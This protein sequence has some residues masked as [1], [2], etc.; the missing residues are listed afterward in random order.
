MRGTHRL[1]ATLARRD[2]LG[3]VWC[4]WAAV[5]CLLAGLSLS[6][7][8]KAAPAPS[9]AATLEYEVK[10]TYLYKLA[11]FVNW[12]PD[13]FEA[14]GAPLRICVAGDDPFGD[15]L[16]HA[17]AGQHFG[18]HPFQVQRLQ[19]LPAATPC[20]IVF[21]SH[22]PTQDLDQALGTLE[23]KPVLTVLDSTLPGHGGVVQFVMDH[24]HVKFAIDVAAAARNHLTIN[25]KLLNLALKVR[26]TS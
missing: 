21:V 10:A 8:C 26:G 14:A 22:L 9:P 4:H 6:T 17:V 1:M 18:T 15:Y 2:I 19:A 25:S 12:P 3:A 23:G 13:T 11:P 24:G 5:S 20:Q 16:E 7:I